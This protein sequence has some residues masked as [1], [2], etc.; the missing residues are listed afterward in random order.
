MKHKKQ[1]EDT[2]RFLKNEGM[3]ETSLYS[4][5]HRLNNISRNTDIFNVEAVLTYVADKKKPNGQKASDG[6]KNGILFSYAKFCEQNQIPFSKPNYKQQS[7]IPLIP[8]QSHVEKLIAHLPRNFTAP[9]S[10]MAETAVEAH[11]LHLTKRSQIN[12]EQGTISIIGTKKHDNG[13]HKLKET[14][15]QILREYLATHPQDQP[16]PDTKSLSSAWVRN[17]KKIA[18]KLCQPEINKIPMKNLRNYAGAI[19]Y[20]TM[21]KDPI[22]TMHFMRHKKLERTMDYLRGLTEFTANAEYISKVATTAEE[23]IELLNQGF[24]EQ[25]IFG[26]KHIY[27][28]LKY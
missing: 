28:K 21:G 6:Y 19:F 25:A 1:L 7:P 12:A 3:E 5:K 14:T 22:Q 4:L 24:K 10:I 8:K 18:A 15:A 16:F 2:L 11:E 13:T 9:F 23:A 26:E 20:L 27:T 17:R